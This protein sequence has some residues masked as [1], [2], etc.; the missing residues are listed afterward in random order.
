MADILRHAFDFGYDKFRDRLFRKT[1]DDPEKAHE[2]FVR[3]ANKLCKFKLEKLVL[4]NGAN[5][6]KI[7]FSI[8][9]A[10]GFNKNGDI[11]L[12]FLK[13]LGFD[14]V[15]VG[16]VTADAWNGNERP[17]MKRYS[18][19][20]SLVNWMGLPGVGAERVAENLGKY[21]KVYIP[22]TLNLM[23]TPGKKGKEVLEDLEKTVYLLRNSPRVDR[24][25]L[26]ISCPNT[27]S[28]GDARGEYQ[29]QLDSMLNILT[30]SINHNQRLYLKVSPDL[31]I[32]S[33]RDMVTVCRDYDVMGFTVSNTTTNHD[34]KYIYDSPGKGGA[35][36]NAVYNSSLETQRMIADSCSESL[37]KLIACGGINSKERL[38]ERLEVGN[39]KEVQIFTPLIFSGPKLLRE[40][41]QA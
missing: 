23:A 9:N 34:P 20:V 3:F 17:R 4:D 41:R 1:E 13:Y 39:T 5:Y 24:F 21:S 35:S 28:S 26:N 37:Y 2:M 25:E 6:E 19:T 29:R 12:S 8:S 22:V 10:A 27:H 32:E 18:D 30:N 33:V 7:D 15:V 40:L 11:P 36:G 38:R 14:R 31:D 16:T